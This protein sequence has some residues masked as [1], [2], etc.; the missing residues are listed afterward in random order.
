MQTRLAA[1]ERENEILL[2]LSTDIASLRNTEQ[3]LEIIRKKLKGLLGFTH[4]V[5]ATINKDEMTFSAFLLDPESRSRN[6]PQ[7]AEVIVGAYPLYDGI[8][9]KVFASERPLVFD[10]ETL[11]EKGDIPVYLRM[12]YESGSRQVCIARLLHQGEVLGFWLNYYEERTLVTPGRIRLVEGLANQISVAVS[13]IS[14]N[15]IM[16]GQLHA[17]SRQ[18]R[19]LEEEKIY[20]REEL[21]KIHNR[22]DIIGESP[23]MKEIHQ[24]VRRVA[25]S[26]STVLILGETGTGKELIARAVH[27]NS[28]RRDKMMVKVNCAVLPV[29]LIESELFGHERGSFTGAI[30]RRIGKFELA[31]DGTLFLDEIGEMPL[32]LQVKLLRVLQE[33]EIERIGG[34]TTIKVNVRVIAATNRDLEKEM[35]DGRFRNDLYYRLNIFPI[36]LPPLRERKEDIPVLAAHFIRRY[37]KKTGKG[38]ETLSS[39]ALQE[40]MQYHWPGNVRE[41]EHLLERSVLLATDDTIRQIH[42]PS[43]R[44]LVADHQGAAAAV[45]LVTIDENEREHIMAIIRHCRGRISGPGGAAFILGIPVSTLNSKMKRLGIKKEHVNKE[46]KG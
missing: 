20:L 4:T 1:Q 44:R 29:N 39:R 16:A 18:Q 25:S 34:K 2:S 43:P 23:V 13:N 21:E 32:E 14:A 6:H 40:M 12:S 19:Q 15:E 33:K 5:M 24:L 17:A 22:G 10:L 45:K 36:Q 30:E 46:P 11:M 8:L 7:Y 37:A 35:I 3:L 28:P 26:D 9:E 42:L 31:H 27:H 38:I 41:L